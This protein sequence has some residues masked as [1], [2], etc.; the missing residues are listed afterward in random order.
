MKKIV[1][2]HAFLSF[3]LLLSACKNPELYENDPLSQLISRVHGQSLLSYH[4]DLSVLKDKDDLMLL[5]NS[6]YARHGLTFQSKLVS[7]YF[8]KC[9]W[10]T[11]HLKNVDNLL[12]EE[13]KSNIRE[14][15]YAE[16]VLEIKRRVKAGD[17]NYGDPLSANEQSMLGIWHVMPMMPSGWSETYAFYS[18]R[19][20]IERPSSLDCASRMV[21]RIGN[22]RIKDNVLMIAFTVK[23]HIVG[24]RYV[25]SAG[26]CASDTELVE[27]RVVVSSINDS[28]VFP[29]TAASYDKQYSRYVVLLNGRKFWKYDENPDAYY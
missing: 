13:D 10:Y 24:G 20:V 9:K 11:P 14:I 16:S 22:W 23:A 12:T 2:Q 17:V 5:R 25:E 18:N 7:E 21:C 6:I 19:K 8:G 1:I 29:V 28:E 27:G 26:S 3:I 4:D 15:Q